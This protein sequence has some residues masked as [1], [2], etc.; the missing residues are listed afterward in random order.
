MIGVAQIRRIIP[1]RHPILLVDRVLE[2]EPGRSLTAAKA[3]TC[4]E[5]GFA[6]DREE[7]PAAL[8]IESWAQSAVLLS[9]WEQPNPDVLAGKVELAGA[10]DD[11]RFGR[12]VLPGD[13]VE[14]RVRL[15]R[16]IADTSIL[17]GESLVGAS[18]VMSVGHF[19]VAL[20]SIDVLR[21]ETAPA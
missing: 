9:V 16:A 2:V 10:I 3:V 13:V 4:S 21:P 5:P 20:R 12:P 14:H 1:H 7:Y 6:E 19:V 11:V 17:E 15:V 8:L 18:T